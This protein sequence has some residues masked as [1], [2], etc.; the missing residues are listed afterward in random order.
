MLGNA[1]SFL[2][3]DEDVK[4]KGQSISDPAGNLLFAIFLGI[5]PSQ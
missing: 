1:K 4:C 5:S 3:E 2:A